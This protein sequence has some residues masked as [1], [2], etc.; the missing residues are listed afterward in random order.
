MNLSCGRCDK[1]F[2]K[3]TWR[4]YCDDCLT[5]FTSVRDQVHA[6]QNPQ[7]GVHACGKFT[8]EEGPRSFF[9]PVAERN[10]CGLCGSTELEQGYGFG[11]GQGC[12]VYNW[13]DNCGNFLDFREDAEPE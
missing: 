10:A 11:S 1:E 7:P 5:F 6:A 8:K 2:D 3:E 13:C 9:N 4:G 12:G